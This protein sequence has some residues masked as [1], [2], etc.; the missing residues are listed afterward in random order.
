MANAAGAV[1]GGGAAW[2][3]KSAAVP[4]PIL[5]GTLKGKP[6]RSR[7]TAQYADMWNC[8][9]AFGDCAVATYDD[10]WAPIRDACERIRRDPASLS[11][12][13]TV[14]VNFTDEA[15]PIVPTSTPFS[16]SIQQI[17]DR[18]AEYAARGVEHMSTIP[19]PWNEEGLDQLAAV[20][21][22]LRA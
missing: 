11:Q 17:A 18:F 5:I 20:L 6:R 10:A 7:L 9:I 15:Y 4:R 2:L 16:G 14:A 8:M 12:G 1:R 21:E 19:H 3:R 13:A 22:Y